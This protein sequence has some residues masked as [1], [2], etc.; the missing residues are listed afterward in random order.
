MVTKDALTTDNEG[1]VLTTLCPTG[2][3]KGQTTTKQKADLKSSI[4]WD[5]RAARAHIVTLTACFE[6]FR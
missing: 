2:V 5:P 1:S 3:R 4:T 6:K